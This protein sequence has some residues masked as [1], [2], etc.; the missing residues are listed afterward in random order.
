MDGACSL[1]NLVDIL[2]LA[3]ETDNFTLINTGKSSPFSFFVPGWNVISFWIQWVCVTFAGKKFGNYFLD[4]VKQKSRQ[5]WSNVLLIK[6]S[7]LR[8]KATGTLI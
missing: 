3:C 5:R 6:R 2:K 1:K 7:Q 4:S 8:S